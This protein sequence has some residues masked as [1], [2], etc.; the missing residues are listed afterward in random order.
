MKKILIVIAVVIALLVI[1]RVGYWETHYNREGV[2][3]EVAD[4]LVTITDTLGNEWLM[5][6]ESLQVGDRVIM[7]MSTQ[8]TEETIMDDAIVSITLKGE[9]R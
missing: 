4:D 5:D 2:V 8:G 1:G 7:R 6:G 3:T 9:R